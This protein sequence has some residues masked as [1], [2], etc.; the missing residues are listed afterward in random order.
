ML[1]MIGGE[2]GTRKVS[3]LSQHSSQLAAATTVDLDVVASTAR[4]WGSRSRLG[5]AVPFEV[6]RFAWSITD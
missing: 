2:L 6:S 1:V 5:L 3:I 4:Y